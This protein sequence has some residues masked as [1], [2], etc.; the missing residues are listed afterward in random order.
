[1]NTIEGDVAQSSNDS[2]SWGI[3]CS[4]NRKN[5]VLRLPATTDSCDTSEGDPEGRFFP[6]Y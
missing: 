6:F 3:A 2:A 1:V 4:T 5:R